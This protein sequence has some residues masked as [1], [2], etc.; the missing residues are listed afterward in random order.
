MSSLNQISNSLKDKLENVTDG[1]QHLWQRARHAITHFT[2]LA[3]DEND[4]VS[5]QVASHWGVLPAEVFENS[6]ALEVQLEA[7]GMD[8]DDFQISVNQQALSIKGK[9]S[10]S[11]ARTEGRYH[12][13]ERAYGSF[14]RT[15]PLPCRVDDSKAAAKY[16]EGVLCITL[17]KKSSE[18][19]KRIVVE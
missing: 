17:P 18:Q 19:L 9:R 10:S 3:N 6:D 4:Q 16:R 1:W 2:P 11:S 13:T 15:I 8:G 5:R 14:E 7:P 12:V